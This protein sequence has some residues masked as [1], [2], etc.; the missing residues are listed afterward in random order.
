MAAAAASP[1]SSPAAA[2]LLLHGE[3][4]FA[5]AQRAR[6]CF[7]QW[8]AE[9]GGTDHEILDAAVAN[10]GEALRILGRL[11]EALQTLPFFGTGKVVWFKNC[12]FLAEDRT[13]SSQAVT[14]ALG[15]LGEELKTF[16][17]GAVRLIISAPKVDRRKTL[18]KTLEKLGKVEVFPGL[19]LEDKDWMQQAELLARQALRERGKDIADETLAELITRVGPNARQLY[20]EI[21]KLA[22]YAGNRREIEA[23]DVALLA[24]VNKSGRAFALADALGDR[25]LPRLLRTLDEELWGMRSDKQ[26]SEIG[27]LYG[28]IG[29]VRAMILLKEMLREGW[30][31]PETDYRRF[32][33]Q[34]AK[35]PADRLP[36]DK[37][38]NPLAINAYVLFRALP[39]SARYSTAELVNGMEALLRCNLRLISSNADGALV[40]QQTL[41]GLVGQPPGKAAVRAGGDARRGG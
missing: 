16:R 25:D 26:K 22:T 34:L 38:Y 32:A 6:H 13:S 2:L 1:S 11:R 19:S 12:S 41:V 36:A 15:E 10:T 14:K 8:T 18:Y 39:Q 33:A 29:K 28:L 30:I 37:R 9:V 27:I 35:V 31:K 24:T 40:L 21:E 4:D 5:L 7:Q 23:G 17:W 3:D 20:S